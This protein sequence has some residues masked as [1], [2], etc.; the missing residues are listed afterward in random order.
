MATASFKVFV[1]QA[2]EGDT[3]DGF[4][5]Q[6]PTTRFTPGCTG[7]S[8]ERDVETPGGIRFHTS[9]ASEEQLRAFLRSAA[10]RPILELLEQSIRKPEVLLCGADGDIELVGALRAR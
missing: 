5:A 3:L 7:C 6:L 9:W 10:I 8:V 4:R 1:E 2:R